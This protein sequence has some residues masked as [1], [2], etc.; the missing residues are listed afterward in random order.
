MNSPAKPRSM[1]RPDTSR[2]RLLYGR[3]RAHG[4]ARL[5]EVVEDADAR[6]ARATVDLAA[7]AAELALATGATA[8]EAT[9][10][11]LQVLG[12]DDVRAHVNITFTTV[13]ITQHRS[14]EDD[15]I[16]V[17]RVVAS[18]G[19]DHQ[20]LAW[21]VAL[22]GDLAAGRIDL[23]SARADFDA[24]VDAPQTYRRWVQ[25]LAAFGMGVTT[26]ALLGGGLVE[27]LLAGLVTAVV[28]I[29]LV[30]SLIRGLSAFFATALASS[31][32]TVVA[33]LIM[34]SRA[35]GGVFWL[36]V[37]P[38]LIVASGMVALLAGVGVVAAG[39]DAIDATTSPPRREP[40]RSWC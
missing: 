34:W 13:T 37:S 35:H 23:E 5:K 29:A 25:V 20:R 16:T 28:D 2:R 19:A 4:H 12:T 1:S 24:G 6:R 33:L 22:V 32:P 9:T 17:M 39:R 21:L 7:R 10:L 30:G 8:S 38:S 15:P 27:I 31:V 26:T 36:Q 3:R 40:S 14:L 11:A 18:R